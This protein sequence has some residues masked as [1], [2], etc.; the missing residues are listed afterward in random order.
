VKQYLVYRILCEILR[1]NEHSTLARFTEARITILK[2]VVSPVNKVLETRFKQVDQK[3][4][5]WWDQPVAVLCSAVND[6]EA[7]AELKDKLVWIVTQAVWKMS[8]RQEQERLYREDVEWATKELKRNPS[9]LRCN[10]TEVRRWREQVWFFFPFQN[11]NKLNTIRIRKTL[12][13][14]KKAM[15]TKNHLL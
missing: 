13:E 12:L 11:P 7:L 14:R 1:R 15:I 10:E 4:K 9:L 8:Q 5:W 3:T 2:T 6:E